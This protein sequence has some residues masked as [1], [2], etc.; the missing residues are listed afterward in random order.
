MKFKGFG[1]SKPRYLLNDLCHAYICLPYTSCGSHAATWRFESHRILNTQYTCDT[2]HNRNHRRSHDPKPTGEK[3]TTIQGLEPMVVQ[4]FQADIQLC[5]ACQTT[6]FN[7]NSHKY[8]CPHT[9]LPPCISALLDQCVLSHQTLMDFQQCKHTHAH[10]HTHT[11]TC[12][13]TLTPT[14]TH[15]HTARARKR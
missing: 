8:L 4:C 3:Y 11:H 9:W 14:N 6:L 12:T 13:H 7:Q 5:H 10:K 2:W 15:M 1:I